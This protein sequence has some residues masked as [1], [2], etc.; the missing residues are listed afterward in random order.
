MG[1]GEKREVITRPTRAIA[2]PQHCPVGSA[3]EVSHAGNDREFR[4]CLP[5]DIDGVA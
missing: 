2:D 5:D 4:S 3:S 1:A